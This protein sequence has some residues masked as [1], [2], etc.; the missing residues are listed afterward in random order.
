[1]KVDEGLAS[2]RSTVGS[3]DTIHA[4][5]QWISCAAAIILF[6]LVPSSH[7]VLSPLVGSSGAYALGTVLMLGLVAAMP[8]VW[9]Q[10]GTSRHDVRTKPIVALMIVSA[11][12]PLLAV[13]AFNLLATVFAGPLD[14]NRGDML[15]IIE[16]AI[17]L[18][19]EGGN[20]YSIH[21]VPW[22]APLS[23]G[24]V[25]WLPFV[26]P[27]VLRIDLRVITLAMQFVVPLSLLVAAAFTVR[28]G[29]TAKSIS[30]L[31]LALALTFNPDLQRFHAIGHTQIYWPLLLAFTGLLASRRYTASGRCAR[32]DGRGTHDVRIDR[33]GLFSVPREQSCSN[34]ASGSCLRHCGGCAI[35][36]VSD[37]RPRKAP[38]CD[39]RG[40]PQADE[41]LRLVLDDL[42]AEHVWH[43]GPSS[44]TRPR[45]ATSNWFRS[46]RCSPRMPSP[47][48]RYGAAVDPNHGWSSAC[49]CSA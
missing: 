43:H 17:S 32:P 8:A 2:A 48:A 6:S 37:R 26:V 13:V 4:P 41:G 12:I 1:M 18:F 34:R 47:G 42:D 31:S 10:L 35:S 29:E 21:K 40:L 20:P 45:S 9:P 15:V 3:R 39:V 14:P 19:L 27:H 23:Y 30:L 7:N 11:G 5:M 22:D 46:S 36:S 25:L 49:S 44:R 33:P 38:L 24:P 16:H 28:R